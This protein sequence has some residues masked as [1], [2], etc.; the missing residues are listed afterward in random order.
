MGSTLTLR[1]TWAVPCFSLPAPDLS[2]YA[3][4]G[5][6]E[7]NGDSSSWAQSC[8]GSGRGTSCHAH[9]WLLPFSESH[10]FCHIAHWSSLLSCQPLPA[11]APGPPSLST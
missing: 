7:A 9:P 1:S 10:F 8:G 11:V 4:Q 5:Y 2:G 6:F 3:L